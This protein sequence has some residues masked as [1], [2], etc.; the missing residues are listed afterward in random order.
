MCV[1]VYLELGLDLSSLAR[2]LRSADTEDAMLADSQAHLVADASGPSAFTVPPVSP[3]PDNLRAQSVRKSVSVDSFSPLARDAAPRPNRGH[4]ASALEA[5]R[6][7]IFDRS[8]TREQV[9]MYNG[10]KRGA[11]VSSSLRDEYDN[12]S[13]VERSES[14]PERYTGMDNVK[15]IRGGDL[16]LP[17]RTTTLS[18][19]SSMSSIMTASSTSSTEDGIHTRQAMRASIPAVTAAASSRTGRTRSGSLGVYASHP[20]KRM[21]IN[22]HV[23]DVS[24]LAFPASAPRLSCLFASSVRPTRTRL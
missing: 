1:G 18:T 13:D 14:F 12:D 17:S 3:D 11:S 23:S 20:A 2:K 24:S 15:P 5:P 16:P 9:Q 8:P 10:R 7:L 22:T 6:N 21:L 19:T 4:T